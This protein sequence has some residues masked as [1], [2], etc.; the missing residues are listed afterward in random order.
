MPELPEV[1]TIKRGLQEKVVGKKISQILIWR[2]KSFKG[3]KLRVVGKK[4]TEI[5]RQAKVLI[6]KL[7]DQLNLLIHLKMTGQVIFSDKVEPENLEPNSKKPDENIYSVSDLPNKYTRVVIVFDD[8]SVVFFNDL[9][10]FGWVKVVEDKDLEKELKNFSGLEPFDK[11]FS[12]EYLKKV[13]ESTTRPVKVAIMDQEKI[14]GVGNIYACEALYCAR[15]DPRKEAKKVAKNPEKVEKL[16]ECI[17]RVL[18]KGINNRGT[19][20]FD[21]AFRDL[22]GN[23]GGMQMH[24]KVYNREDKPCPE[25]SGKVKKIK[26]AG[27]GTYFCP[28]CQK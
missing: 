6:I 12:T 15:I 13:L 11:E 19:T 1:E 17:S 18:K 26:I 4:I 21:E 28:K 23:P 10:V 14:A 20:D 22:E 5:K 9:R 3:D 7:E 16:K 2:E 25:C 24:L 27:R 8:Q